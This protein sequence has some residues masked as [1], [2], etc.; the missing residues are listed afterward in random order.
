MR[1]ASKIFARFQFFY[2]LKFRNCSSELETCSGE[3]ETYRR[4]RRKIFLLCLKILRFF[5]FEWRG[6]Y[7]LM[8]PIFWPTTT[9]FVWYM[10]R[11]LQA[12]SLV[13]THIITLQ[14][15]DLRTCRPIS[16]CHV[17]LLPRCFL[18]LFPRFF[19]VPF[20]CCTSASCSNF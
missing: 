3:L 9:A 16:F 13:H 12:A 4:F 2:I 7:P 6:T 14:Q 15:R 18:K 20:A 19:V 1:Y 17:W 8:S 10:I 5:P 11:M